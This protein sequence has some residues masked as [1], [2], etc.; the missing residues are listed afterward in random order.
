M[1]DY[2]SAGEAAALLGVT[3][4]TLYVYV[5]RKGLRSVPVPN[6]RKRRYWRSDVEMLRRREGRAAPVP[7]DIR[8]ESAI[9]LITETDLIY[10][11]RSVLDLIETSSFEA[12]AALLWNIAD[13]EVFTDALPQAP[14]SFGAVRAALAGQ[15]RLNQALALFPLLEE[16]NPRSHDLSR[17]G[18][19]RTGSD[20]LRWFAAIVLDQA[21]P[22]AGPVHKAFGRALRLPAR[23]EDLVRRLLILSADHGMEP[24]TFTVRAVASTGV[25]P[26]RSVSTGLSVAFGRYA[27]LGRWAALAGRLSEVLSDPRPAQPVVRRAQDGEAIVGFQLA[28]ADR[29]DPRA[30]ALSQALQG[31]MSSD[32]HGGRGGARRGRA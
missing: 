15:S 17:V 2:L 8:P 29:Q 7:G 21:Q 16:A 3:V 24:A 12:A 28:Q 9:T 26:W 25:S 20:L 22:D 18:M 31:S 4:E 10:R 1:D 13:A 6:S 23:S 19:A 5:S 11:G 14:A 27:R 32:L 30:G